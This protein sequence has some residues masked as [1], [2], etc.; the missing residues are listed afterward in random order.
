MCT[1]DS[2][3]AGI[4][5]ARD[6][7]RAEGGAFQINHP[8]DRNWFD[9]FG[10]QIVPDAVEVWNI[11]VWLWQPPAPS[12]NDNDF[13][14]DFYDDFLDVGY[15]V[16][17]TGGSDS[18]W[19]ILSPIQGVGQPTTWVYSAG[20]SWKDLTAGIRGARTTISW[21]PPAYL[22]PRLFIEADADG[23][24]TFEAIAGDLVPA[25]SPMRVRAEGAPPLSYVRLVTAGSERQDD[26]PPASGRDRILD[27]VAVGT[28][29]ARSAGRG[30]A[31]RVALRPAR[32]RA[33]HAVPQPARCAGSDL[34]DL[35]DVLAPSSW[36]P[37]RG[38]A[39]L[40]GS[41]DRGR[42]RSGGRSPAARSVAGT[43]RS[44]SSSLSTS[45]S[46]SRSST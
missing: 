20:Q 42:G 35:P 22:G 18:H 45:R 19:R 29:G 39:R 1:R 7:L 9:K 17:A 41:D 34:A 10:L 33:D 43:S 2:S 11:G 15:R 44:R 32:R 26:A 13:S 28:R 12:A 36:S 30:S 31:A 25:G 21:Q 8:S 4:V 40:P 24:G 3:F 5:A 23:N 6:A 46:R 37:T 14:L 27:R 16:A 38:G